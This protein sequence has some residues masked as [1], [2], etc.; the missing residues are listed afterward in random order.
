MIENIY[1]PVELMEYKDMDMVVK[2]FKKFGKL[3]LVSTN[4]KKELKNY[5]MKRRV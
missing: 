2:I 3:G 5:Q 4:A 1:P